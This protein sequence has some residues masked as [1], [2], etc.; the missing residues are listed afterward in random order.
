[1]TVGA[2]SRWDVALRTAMKQSHDIICDIQRGNDPVFALLCLGWAAHA[3]SPPM[4][5]C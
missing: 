4:E 1:M 5:L 3:P 2:S